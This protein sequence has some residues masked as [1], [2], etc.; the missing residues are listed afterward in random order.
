MGLREF[1]RVR[2]EPGGHRRLFCDD[3]F[4]LY[5]WYDA[6]G[7]N[8]LGFQLVYFEGDNQKA[9]TWTE[10]EGYQHNEVDG[11]DSSR[12]NKTPFLVPDG[13][14]APAALLARLEP[15]LA[16]VDPAVR[17]LVLNRLAGYSVAPPSGA[18]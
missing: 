3:E 14:F 2:Q 8:L 12:F 17:A 1:S 16:D 6:P 13:V 15:R 9:F 7:G 18:Q 4:D 11:W 5:A 10:A